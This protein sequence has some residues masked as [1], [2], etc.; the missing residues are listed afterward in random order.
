[1][2]L[3]HY[4]VH[5]SKIINQ[6]DQTKCKEIWTKKELEM[7]LCGWSK[8]ATALGEFI[9][10]TSSS[11][12]SSIFVFPQLLQLHSFALMLDGYNSC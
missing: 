7:A 12:P 1:M 4:T 5:P 10:H 2:V 11:E 9:F 6:G 3:V 8:P